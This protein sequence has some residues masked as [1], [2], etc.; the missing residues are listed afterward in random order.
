VELLVSEGGADVAL[1]DRWG[2]TAADE[3]RRV[4]AALVAAFLEQA[5]A[6]AQGGEAE[7]K[8]A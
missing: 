2:A 7:K 1:R 5:T 3:A 8:E 4:G 6:G